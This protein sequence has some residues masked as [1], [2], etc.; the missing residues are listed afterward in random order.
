VLV[1]PMSSCGRLR[2]RC[3]E[4]RDTAISS[5]TERPQERYNHSTPSAARHRAAWPAG[6]LL[7]RTDGIVIGFGTHRDPI[8]RRCRVER[9]WRGVQSPG[10]I[11]K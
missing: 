8:E 6:P 10:M 4:Q 2:L 5:D 9:P 11:M 3:V 7:V 1:R